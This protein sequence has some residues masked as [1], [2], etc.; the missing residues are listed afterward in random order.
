MLAVGV[1]SIFIC[2]NY[3]QAELAKQKSVIEYNLRW[4]NIGQVEPTI[5]ASGLY[6]DLLVVIRPLNSSSR[7]VGT[8]YLQKYSSGTWKTARSWSFDQTGT[9]KFSRTVKGVSG[10][11]YRIRV[12]G[13]VGGESFSSVSKSVTLN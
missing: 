1:A 12:S 5:E 13:T 3:T 8:V 11:K 7:S 6:L 9:V 4:E 10:T 2:P